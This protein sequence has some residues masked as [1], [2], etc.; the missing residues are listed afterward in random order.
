M[1]WLPGA[2]CLHLFRNPRAQELL[3]DAERVGTLGKTNEEISLHL[4]FFSKANIW[5]M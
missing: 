4:R 3:S 2:F 1:S 5:K